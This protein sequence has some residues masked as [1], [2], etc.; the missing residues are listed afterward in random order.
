MSQS[1][2]HEHHQL[3]WTSIC[4]M[5]VKDWQ[6]KMLFFFF[7]LYSDFLVPD[8]LSQVQEEE[9]V[10]GV[11][12][13]LDESQHHPVYPGSTSAST[14]TTASSSSS[15]QTPV[16][17]QVSSS[18]QNCE[19]SP[20]FLSPE[21]LEA[22]ASHK[23]NIDD[24]AAMT[25]E[26]KMNGVGGSSPEVFDEQQHAKEVVSITIEWF[27]SRTWSVLSYF[28]VCHMGISVRAA[29]APRRLVHVWKQPGRSDLSYLKTF[30]ALV[31]ISTCSSDAL[32]WPWVSLL[33][34]SSEENEHFFFFFF[35]F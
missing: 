21:P 28:A 35:F 6:L 15:V 4:E 23:M 11:Q 3:F 25:E 31:L 32:I 14:T 29:T 17:S 8:Y 27:K 16:I 10:L 26:T 18:T 20:G 9:E 30:V 5:S 12:Y 19:N 1:E 22:P 34:K 7:H 33:T 24:K 13:E 2:N